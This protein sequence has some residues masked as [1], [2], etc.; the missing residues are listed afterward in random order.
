VVA[1][2]RGWIVEGVS[3]VGK[4]TLLKHYQALVA[5]LRPAT[6]KLFISEHYTER[7][8]EDE[9]AAMRLQ[10]HQVCSHVNELMD[11]L[12]RFAKMKTHGKFSGNTTNAV[13]DVALERFLGKGRKINISND[14]RGMPSPQVT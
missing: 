10:I 8:L 14:I 9:R 2:F 1:P 11:D 12:D 6:T 13:I 3:G 5:E 4:T 7:V